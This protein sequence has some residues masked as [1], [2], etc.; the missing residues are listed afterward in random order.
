MLLARA[1]A[2]LGRLKDGGV[3]QLAT[4]AIRQRSAHLSSAQRHDAML[5]H[6]EAPTHLPAQDEEG[7]VGDVAHAEHIVTANVELALRHST[8]HSTGHSTAWTTAQVTAQGVHSTAWTTAQRSA[9]HSFSATRHSNVCSACSTQR[10]HQ[11]PCL[12][13]HKEA[14]C[15]LLPLLQPMMVARRAAGMP[16]CGASK[17]PAQSA[18]HRQL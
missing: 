7:C 14:A 8:G 10:A 13:R 12:M 15:L 3:V 6:R 5:P 18:P 11:M 2:T 17:R 16:A 4:Q 9:G 1:A